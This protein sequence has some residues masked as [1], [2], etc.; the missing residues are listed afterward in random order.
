M[1]VPWQFYIVFRECCH[2]FE[3]GIS[4][5]LSYIDHSGNDAADILARMGLLRVNFIEYD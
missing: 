4:W 2:L 1:S 5:S 3:S